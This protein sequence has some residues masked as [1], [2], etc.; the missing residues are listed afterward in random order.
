MKHGSIDPLRVFVSLSLPGGPTLTFDTNF[1]ALTTP[2]PSNSHLLSPSARHFA[3]SEVKLFSSP[4]ALDFFA[5]RSH[6]SMAKW[7]LPFMSG[8]SFT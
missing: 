1:T 3:F 6:R 2:F 5:K 7:S 4:Q 8:S